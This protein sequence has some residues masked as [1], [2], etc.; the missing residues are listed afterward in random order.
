MAQELPHQLTDEIALN[1]EY[2]QLT[3]DYIEANADEATEE[4][5]RESER[6]YDDS[7]ATALLLD[8][9]AIENDTTGQ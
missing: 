6:A 8:A 7:N 2:L 5:A 4:G 9:E 1:T 3:R